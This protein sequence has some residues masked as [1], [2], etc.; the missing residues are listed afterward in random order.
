M[1]KITKINL[2]TATLNLL[3]GLF[4]YILVTKG[5]AY[6]ANPLMA[7]LFDISPELFL[8]FKITITPILLWLFTKIEKWPIY[9]MAGFYSLVVGW[10]L[11]IFLFYAKLF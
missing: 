3:D 2:Y 4:T 9:I 11:V 10:Q 1:A 7:A 6:E 8:A 5:I